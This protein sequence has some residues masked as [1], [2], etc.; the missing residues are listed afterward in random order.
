MG[1]FTKDSDDKIPNTRTQRKQ[2]WDS[3]DEF[4]TCLDKAGIVNA[5]DSRHSKDVSKNCG[6]EEQAFEEN[7]ANSWVKYFK[8][9]RLVDYQ[10]KQFLEKVE[11]ENAQIVNLTPSSQLEGGAPRKR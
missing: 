4:F 7:C 1:W 2:C 11:K 8:E 6:K 10:K 9:K 5:L 3:R